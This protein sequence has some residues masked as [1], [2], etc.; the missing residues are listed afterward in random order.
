MSSKEDYIFIF[1]DNNKFEMS[2]QD[3]IEISPNLYS[4]TVK[5]NDSKIIKLPKYIRY[6]DFREFVEI[7]RNYISRLRQFNQEQFFISISLIIQNYKINIAQ[8][9]QISEYFE[10]N[11]FSKLLI[12]DCILAKNREKTNSKNINHSLNVNNS[13]SLL[14]LS[15]NK[16]REINN[17]NKSKSKNINMEDDLE[18][19]WLELFMKSLDIAGINLDSFFNTIY[20][21]QDYSKNQLWSLD[22]KIIDEIYEKFS[23]NLI[24]NKYTVEI[25][26]EKYINLNSIENGNK[27]IDLK[28][29][30]ETVN[31]LMKKRNQKDFFYLL[32][33]EYLRIMSEDNINEL[34]N[35]PNPTFILKIN[36]NEIDN[37]YEEYTLNNLFSTNDD[38]KLVLIVYYKKNEDTFNVS[39]K[40][41]KNN[42]ETKSIFDIMTFLSLGIIDELN[43]KQI[44]VKSLSNNKSMYEI[45]KITNFKKSKNNI[46]SYKGSEI[47]DYFTFKLFLKPCYIYILLSNYLYYNLENLS[48]SENI[49]KLNKNILSIIIS[50]KYLNK[51]EESNLNNKNNNNFDVIV[52][53]LINW[54]NDEINIVEDISDIIKNI[55]WEN[56]SLF[57]MFEFFIKYSTNFSSEDIE[58]IFSKALLK[59]L[60]RFNS[61]LE[62]ISK[63]IIKAMVFS[64]NKI[65][66]ISIF[67]ENKKIKKFNLFELLSQRRYNYSELNSKNIEKKYKTTNN[68]LQ[69]S[70]DNKENLYNFKNKAVTKNNSNYKKMNNDINQR[71]I[72]TCKVRSPINLRKED[73]LNNTNIRNTSHNSNNI[74]Y[75]NFYSN[76]NNN[77]NI[78][79][80]LDNKFKKIQKPKTNNERKSLDFKMKQKKNKNEIISRNKKNRV[81]DIN[82]SSIST[83]NHKEQN[84]SY[85]KTINLKKKLINLGTKNN[86]NKSINIKNLKLLQNKIRQREKDVSRNKIQKNIHLKTFIDEKNKTE[87]NDKISYNNYDKDNPKKIKDFNSNIGDK[88]NKN[89]KNSKKNKFKLKDILSIIDK[90]KNK[91]KSKCNLKPLK[92]C[93]K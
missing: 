83:I 17:A 62:L 86:I 72:K 31:F 40:L 69:I 34:N 66:Y 89:G 21:N 2:K 54:L 51:K 67:S 82:L 39:I 88:T 53:F 45:Y 20:K 92:N 46:I 11:S 42:N 9:L 6:E 65:N 68:S 16:L 43:N 7:Y 15:Y 58:Y 23:Y 35:L 93:D 48:N 1:Q 18:N 90:K 80:R 70:I 12:K 64:S 33:N 22:K 56:V 57:K 79:I 75:N 14:I 32:S 47:N 55:K 85:I 5:V 4:Q 27:K 60:N 71:E 61:N 25:N 36:I 59:I 24:S 74:C 87:I 52:E 44:N 91:N 77:F 3:F 50:K 73:S 76:Y 38:L 19:I 41:S 26:E 63:E 10:N 30:E 37:Y 49:A 81:N 8:L 78:N 84:L 28:I 13:I 29:L